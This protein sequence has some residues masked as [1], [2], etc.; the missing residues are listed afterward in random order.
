MRFL[1]DVFLA[2][3]GFLSGLM[4]VKNLSLLMDLCSGCGY[5]LSCLYFIH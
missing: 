4:F 1:M 2:Y 3:V 5:G